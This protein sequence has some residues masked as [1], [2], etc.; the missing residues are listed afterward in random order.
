KGRSSKC[1]VY[2]PTDCMVPIYNLTTKG[3]SVW[4]IGKC[5]RMYKK[6]YPNCGIKSRQKTLKKSLISKVIGT[7]SST[8]SGLISQKLIMMQIPT[9]SCKFQVSK[10]NINPS[11]RL[12]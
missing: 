1:N 9:N 5:V 12:L 3:V 7:S 4:M 11:W 10:H 8:C 6:K 2:L